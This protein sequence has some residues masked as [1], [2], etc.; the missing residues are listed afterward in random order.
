MITQQIIRLRTEVEKAEDVIKQAEARNSPITQLTPKGIATPTLQLVTKKTNTEMAE[1]IDYVDEL[2]GKLSE[3]E[4]IAGFA[5]NA[6][7]GLATAFVSM[8][9]TGE[10]SFKS[11]VVTMLDGLRQIIFGL[12]AKAI[13][14]MIA[15]EATKGLPGL[16]LA[17]VGVTAITAMFAALPK[18]ENGGIV[19]GGYY[20]GDKITARVNSGEMIL[21]RD[22]QA[23]LFAMANGA[24]GGGL[25]GEV[26]FEI[27][28][29][30]LI[31]VLN[32]H[33]RKFN[34]YR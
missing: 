29:D 3:T 9:E 20:T 12:L 18:F 19:G 11:L 31:G 17:G 8:A 7:N 5:G 4:T 21:N 1:Y 14:G 10:M 28:G 30:K 6:I 15:G 13:A 27:S 23:N 34:S 22:Q 33:N 24:S 2:K 32:N 26:R 16:I 25:T